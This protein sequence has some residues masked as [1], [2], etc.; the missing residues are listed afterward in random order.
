MGRNHPAYL[1]ILR[2]DQLKRSILESDLGVLVD[3][4]LT[5]SQPCG[6][7]AKK[8][9]TVLCCTGSVTRKWREAIP[10][11]A[12]VRAHLEHFVQFCAPQYKRGVEQLGCSEKV[13]SDD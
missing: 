8:T 13:H 10:A 1:Y 2:A 6:L 11:S 7:V 12:Q 9:S 5:I 4:K 3:R